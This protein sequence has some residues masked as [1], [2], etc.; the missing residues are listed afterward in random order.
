MIEIDGSMGEGGG[1]VLRSAL[2][3]S[4][5]TGQAFHIYNIRKNR[6]KSGLMR[7]HLMAVQAAARISSANVAGDRLGSP[8]LSFLPDR[9]TP[10]EYS[11]DIGTAGSATLVL[12]TVIPPLLAARKASRITVIG[13]THVPFSPSWN[14][15]EEIFWPSIAR[16]GVRGETAAR[17]FGFYPKGGGRVGCTVEPAEVLAPYLVRERGR[18]TRL[19]IVS[20]VGNLPRAIAERQLHSAL[21]TLKGR[22]ERGLPMDIETRE[23]T[24]FGQGTFIFIKG[25]YEHAV[26]GFTAL[27]ERGKP[28]E[29]VGAEAAR[30]LLEHHESGEPIDPHLA[31]QLVLYLARASAGSL[32]RTSRLTS[33][34]ATNLL[35]AGYFLELA[36]R[37]EGSEGGPGAV[38]I[39]PI[40]E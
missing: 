4:C 19:S 36:C 25:E 5:L 31:D 20:A 37:V 6:S 1:Q 13:G 34:L 24:I 8:E 23:L 30:E 35:V 28:A 33:H 14:Y 26:A 2:S 9:I 40:P 29:A 39:T 15:F 38:V 12:Q 17:S 21:S 10:G 7:Q 32:F 11:F 18:L 27:G 3:L 16:L 22:L